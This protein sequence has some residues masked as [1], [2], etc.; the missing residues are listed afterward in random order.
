MGVMEIPFLKRIATIYLPDQKKTN[1]YPQY[2][3]M[4]YAVCKKK[5]ADLRLLWI[6]PFIKNII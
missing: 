1:A 2:Y 5:E 6:L 3:Q 4:H